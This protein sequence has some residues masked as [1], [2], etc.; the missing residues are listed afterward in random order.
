MRLPAVAA[1][2][3]SLAAI[4]SA[5]TLGSISINLDTSNAVSLGTRVKCPIAWDRN[6][7]CEDCPDD[8]GGGDGDDDD[9]QSYPPD[10]PFPKPRPSCK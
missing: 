9:D 1:I 8:G 3:L 4:S 5:R 6:F 10:Y 2:L 7:K